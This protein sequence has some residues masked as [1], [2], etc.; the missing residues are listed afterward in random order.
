MATRRTKSADS[1]LPATQDRGEPA[2]SEAAESS[3]NEGIYQDL[4]HAIMEH[5]LLAG[6]KLVEERLCEVTGASRARSFRCTAL[7]VRETGA[8]DFYSIFSKG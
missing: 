4:L 8:P 1:E 2:A 3:V 6:T 5:R 7:T